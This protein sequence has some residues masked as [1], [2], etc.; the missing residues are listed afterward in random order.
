MKIF[1][2]VLNLVLNLVRIVGHRQVI[3]V[4][5]L[6]MVRT[7]ENHQFFMKEKLEDLQGG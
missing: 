5:V 3:M 2:A 7:G 6:N 4:A 1:S